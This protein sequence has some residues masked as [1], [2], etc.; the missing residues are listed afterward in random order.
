MAI[1]EGMAGHLLEVL[2]FKDLLR[3]GKAVC[4]AQADDPD[5]PL[6]KRS[7][8]GSNGIKFFSNHV[9]SLFL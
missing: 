6:T 1:V 9:I 7:R 3:N 4:P 2:A 5:R 8:D